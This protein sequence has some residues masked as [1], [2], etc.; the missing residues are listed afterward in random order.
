MKSIGKLVVMSGLVSI[1][2]CTGLVWA[3]GP[4]TQRQ[5]N[6]QERI[7]QGVADGQLTSGETRKL[8]RQQGR[9][10]RTK[11]RAASD[12]KITKAE[13]VHLNKMQNRANRNIYR[14]KHNAR[15]Q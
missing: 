15:T 1:F 3:E 10:Q 5:E 2:T 6:Q 13:R 7:G 14:K 11:A 9:I 4:I 12:G 8:E